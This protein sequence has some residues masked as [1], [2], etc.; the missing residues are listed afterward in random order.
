MGVP[1]RWLSP[2]PRK[3]TAG[4]QT[5]MANLVDKGTP[6][7]VATLQGMSVKC[8]ACGWLSSACV[9]EVPVLSQQE[10]TSPVSS[11]RFLGVTPISHTYVFLFSW[12]NL[13]EQ[14]KFQC[15]AC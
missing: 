12:R 5:P 15:F 10:P 11:Y 1:T 2:P 13:H 6:V 8:I 9:V 4:D 14:R 3:F 7:V